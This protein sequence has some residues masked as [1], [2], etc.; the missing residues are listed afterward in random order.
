[1]PTLAEIMSSPEAL[2]KAAEEFAALSS[3]QMKSEDSMNNGIATDAEF[4]AL[5]EKCGN[6]PDIDYEKFCKIG[7]ND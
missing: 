2:D 6:N 5:L 1:M 3:S 4:I 7:V